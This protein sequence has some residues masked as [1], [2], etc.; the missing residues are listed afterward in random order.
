[1]KVCTDACAFGAWAN[2]SNAKSI[3]DIGTGTGL[4]SLMAA[5]RNPEALID[6]VEI[7]EVAARQATENIANSP[8]STKIDVFQT[9]I[10]DYEPGYKYDAILVNPPFY[11]NDLRSPDPKVNQAHHAATLTFEELLKSLVR[12]LKEEESWHILLPIQ[13]SKHLT[14]SALDQDWVKHRE[15]VLYHS[16]K[17]EPFRSLTTFSRLPASDAPN[18]SEKLAIYEPDSSIHTLAFRQLLREF[19]LNF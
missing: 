3:L 18:I 4:L 16:S 1:M 14:A 2:I 6:A 12:L 5:Q 17:H 8:F 19:Y 13:E 15:L 11:Q 10:Q 7:D 9:A